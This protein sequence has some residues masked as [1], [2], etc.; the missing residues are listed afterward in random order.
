MSVRVIS[1]TY[2]DIFGNVTSYYQS[3]AGDKIIQTTKIESNISIE[4]DAYNSFD[5]NFVDKEITIL[6]SKSWLTEGFR[7]GDSI[8]VTFYEIGTSTVVGTLT[9]TLTYVSDLTIRLT[10]YFAPYDNPLYFFNVLCNKSHADVEYS[11]NHILQ[12]NVSGQNSLIDGELS[13]VKFVGVGA[14]S[15]AGSVNG[16]LIGNQSGGYLISSVITRNADAYGNRVHTIVTTFINS[17]VLLQ[18]SF[19][20][21]NCLKLFNNV[22]FIPV[23]NDITNVPFISYSDNANTGYFGQAYNTGVINSTLTTGINSVDYV[24]PTTA[25]VVLE[26]SATDLY[27]GCQ[28]VSIDTDYYKNKVSNQNTLGL[29]LNAYIPLA[30]GTYTSIGGLYTIE[31]VSNTL[32]STTRTIVLIFTPLTGFDTLIS[33]FDSNDRLFNIWLKCGTVNHLLFNDQLTKYVDNQQPLDVNLSTIQRHDDNTTNPTYLNI[34]KTNTEDNIAFY[35]TFDSVP[36]EIIN[37][38]KYEII[39]TDGTSEFTLD[40]VNFDFD[41]YQINALGQYLIND[42]K[43][44]INNLP[45]TSGKKKAILI[46]DTTTDE[47]SLYFPFLNNWKYWVSFLGADSS[48]YPNQNENWVQYADGTTWNLYGRITKSVTDID[49]TYDTL[50]P[51]KD[52]DTEP[53]INSTIELYRADGTLTTSIFNEIMIVK[54]IHT[55]TGYSAVSSWGEITVEQF[56]NSPRWLIS[57]V[58]DQDGNTNNPLIPITGQLATVTNGTEETIITCLVDGNILSSESKFTSKIFLNVVVALGLVYQDEDPIIDQNINF[59]KTQEQ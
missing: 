8:T 59:I 2:T 54:A 3:N 50:L 27:L 37:S 15:V 5:T 28:Y 39:A 57:T 11:I 29:L 4:D 18:S 55:Y 1:N 17:G 53:I 49:Y 33:S 56:E 47:L 24:L 16:S 19:N 6:G 14:L 7:L 40:S 23:S 42:S 52:Y 48:F 22:R 35:T 32:V 36:F 10:A 9:T 41:S 25:T 26:S 13:N 30:V 38:V 46:N 34:K 12:S 51:L 58:V 31:V 43:G 44:V 45:T 21:G 20:Q